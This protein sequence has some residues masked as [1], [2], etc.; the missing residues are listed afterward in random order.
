MWGI[1]GGAYQGT[2]FGALGSLHT[3]ETGA[4][5]YGTTTDNAFFS[6]GNNSRAT[7]F[8]GQVHV[9]GGVYA[10]QGFSSPSD[11][12]LKRD[13]VTVKDEEAKSGSTLDNLLR[14]E[15]LKYRL[16]SHRLTL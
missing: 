1:G 3:G 9:V 8:Y 10:P 12:R 14:L 5:I 2:N 6:L 13:V 7:Y 16:K 11:M 15:V 4:A